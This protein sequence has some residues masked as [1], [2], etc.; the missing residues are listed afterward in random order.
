MWWAKCSHINQLTRIENLNQSDP[1]LAELY[2][3]SEPAIGHFN[4]FATNPHEI[5]GFTKETATC[6]ED[7]PPRKIG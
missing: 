5:T 3:T 6:S 1:Q 4:C 7:V 2:V